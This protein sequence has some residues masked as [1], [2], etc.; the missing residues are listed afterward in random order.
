MATIPLAAPVL[1]KSLQFMAS[2]LANYSRR[3]IRI[4]ATSATTASGGS[5]LQ[6]KLPQEV[7]DLSTFCMWGKLTTESPAADSYCAINDVNMLVEQ[8]QLTCGGKSINSTFEYPALWFMLNQYQAGDKANAHSLISN[9]LD[10]NASTGKFVAP[11]ADINAREICVDKWIGVLGSINPQVIDF[12]LLPE[13]ILTIRFASADDVLVADDDAAGSVSYSLS[14]ISFE[15]DVLGLPQIYYQT[16]QSYQAGGGVLEM[17]F[18]NILSYQAPSQPVG[19]AI[20]Q[21]QV[22]SQSI[23]AVISTVVETTK[24]AKNQAARAWSANVFNSK[25]FERGTSSLTDIE[26]KVNAVSYV[27][28]KCSVARSALSVIHNLMGGSRDTLGSCS[29]SLES[30]TR[31]HYDHYAHLTRFNHINDAGDYDNCLISGINTQTNPAVFTIQ[32]SGGTTAITPISWVFTTASLL[33]SQYKQI[34]VRE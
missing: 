10:I 23:D 34:E 7:M 4:V 15:V 6:V 16:I 14:D 1:P 8:Y 29:K 20:Q 21:F 17:P 25:R 33:V 12:S 31:F 11:A 30:I 19:G 22:A 28:G 26:V 5:I 2:R 18:T 9:T 13:T 32:Y 3:K 24:L 27:Y